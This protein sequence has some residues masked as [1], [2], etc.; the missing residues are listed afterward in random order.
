MMYPGG[1]ECLDLG[2]PERLTAGTDAQALDRHPGALARFRLRN[3]SL[4]QFFLEI[5]GLALIGLRDPEHGVPR[6][7]DSKGICDPPDFL[8]PVAPLR[9]LIPSV[10]HRGPPFFSE[11]ALVI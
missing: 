6:R 4:R 11:R 8:G 1:D 3:R 5:V 7:R 10:R 9:D 2:Q